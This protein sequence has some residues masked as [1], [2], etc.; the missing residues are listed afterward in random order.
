MDKLKMA[1]CGIDCNECGSYKVTMEQDLKA[2]EQM[3]FVVQKSR[4]DWR[5]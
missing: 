3:L 1:A 4:F 5:R 2:A